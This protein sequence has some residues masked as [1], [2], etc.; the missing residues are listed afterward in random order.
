MVAKAMVKIV[1][2]PR[3][4]KYVGGTSMLFKLSHA[5]FPELTTKLSGF[6]MRRYFKNADSLP[7]TNGNLFNTVDYAMSTNG[8]FSFSVPAKTS[9]R[10][11]A[12]AAIFAAVVAGSAVIYLKNK[13][14]AL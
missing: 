2:D 5:I 8:G 9:R 7:P 11:L 1:C 10:Y 4:N 14:H 6:V 13:K 3:S 12:G